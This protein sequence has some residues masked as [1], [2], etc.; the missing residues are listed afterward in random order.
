MYSLLSIT[1]S[2]LNLHVALSLPIPNT[3]TSALA[4]ANT[5]NPADSNQ[6]VNTKDFSS[7]SS[8]DYP[9]ETCASTAPN[10]WSASH[11]WIDEL[12]PA[13]TGSGGTWRLKFKNKKRQPPYAT[14]PLIASGPFTTTR[15]IWSTTPPPPPRQPPLPLRHQ[16]SLHRRFDT[17]VHA[18]L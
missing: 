11:P 6:E 16:H 5:S 3:T 18:G 14:Y 7:S 4:A 12:S 13:S 9:W 10:P 8:S 2:L 15:L 1:F 17:D